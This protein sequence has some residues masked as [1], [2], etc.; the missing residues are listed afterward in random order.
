MSIS[1]RNVLLGAGGAA[2][3]GAGAYGTQS[4]RARHYDRIAEVLDAP[5]V[6]VANPLS[7][8]R[9]RLVHYASLAANGHN[10]QAWRFAFGEGGMSVLPDFTRRTPV[11]DPDDHHLWASLGGAVENLTLAARASGLE[12]DLRFTDERIELA[13]DTAPARV[14]QRFG[15]IPKRQSIRADYDGK[16]LSLE[17]YRALEAAGQ[18]EEVDLVLVLRC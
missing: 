6:P 5:A 12:T 13:F 15:A 7:E 16:A 14:S 9:R 4:L 1:R 3:L 8:G 2:V 11:V 17:D 10:T 18:D